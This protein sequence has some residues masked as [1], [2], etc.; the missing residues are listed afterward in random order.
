M[1]QNWVNH[2]CVFGL[3]E[4]GQLLNMLL[5][6]LKMVEKWIEAPKE[7]QGGSR[8]KEKKIQELLAYGEKCAKL[9]NLFLNLEELQ[10]AALILA[11]VV[12]LAILVSQ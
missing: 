8:E 12:M 9:M 3:L 6:E 5:T 7:T 1:R 11:L 4:V 2:V 10:L